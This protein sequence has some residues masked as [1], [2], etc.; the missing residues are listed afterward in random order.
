M[1]EAVIATAAFTI[2]IYYAL[3]NFAALRL[4]RRYRA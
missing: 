1:L 4:F 3:T 2:L